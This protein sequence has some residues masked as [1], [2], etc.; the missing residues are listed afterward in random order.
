MG[1]KAWS[2]VAWSRVAWTTRRSKGVGDAEGV[3]QEMWRACDGE[4][5][6]RHVEGVNQEVWRAW[7]KTWR[8]RGPRHVEGVK[9][10]VWRAWKT[11]W[12]LAPEAGLQGP[13][14]WARTGGTRD[15]PD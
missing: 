9:Q 5:G 6:R 4:R 11:L 10:E 1:D 2:R 7:T 12:T 13:R 14:P 15:Q 3:D 8:G